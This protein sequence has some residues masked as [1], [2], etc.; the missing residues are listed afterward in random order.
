MVDLADRGEYVLRMNFIM[1][2]DGGGQS[3]VRTAP[4]RVKAFMGDVLF[5]LGVM[6]DADVNDPN[7]PLYQND[8]LEDAN[9]LSMRGVHVGYVNVPGQGPPG[10]SFA[11]GDVADF[12]ETDFFDD[13]ELAGVRLLMPGVDMTR[14]VGERADADLYVY[15]SSGNLID[16][17][18][19]SGQVESIE[20]PGG[21]NYSFEVRAVTGGVSYML[22]LVLPPAVAGMHAMRVGARFLADEA[23]V[24]PDALG[25]GALAPK[26]GADLALQRLGLVPKAGSPARE[27]RVALPADNGATLQR[28]S[29]TLSSASPSGTRMTAEQRRK[30][31]TL[32]HVKALATAPGIR[33]ASTNRIVEALASVPADPLYARQRWHYEMIGLP[34]AWDITTGA[35]GVTIAVVDSGVCPFAP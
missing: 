20:L 32:L 10:R 13:G 26:A 18:V 9:G 21:D 4:V 35:P 30:L 8:T 33:A 22:E 16:A 12:S 34:Q 27:M 17:S 6:I 2:C 5:P 1:Q 11:A 25:R 28:L 29:P 14:P 19:G 3:L 31:T 15:D 24:L 7:A 23:L